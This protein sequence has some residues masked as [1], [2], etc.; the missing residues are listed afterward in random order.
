MSSFCSCL[1]NSL[2]PSPAILL[3]RAPLWGSAWLPCHAQDTPNCRLCLPKNQQREKKGGEKEKALL[4]A[5]FLL[6]FQ[7]T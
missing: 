3:E 6:P 1:G 5:V 2:F 7:Y 4:L